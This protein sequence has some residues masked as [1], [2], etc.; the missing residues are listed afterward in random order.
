MKAFLQSPAGAIELKETDGF[1]PAL[2]FVART[3]ETESSSVPF[4]DEGKGLGGYACR[5]DVKKK[6]PELK[7]RYKDSL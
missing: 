1:I 7:N 4:P 2:K 5:P 3:L 6:S